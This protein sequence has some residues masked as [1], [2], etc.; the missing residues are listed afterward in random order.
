MKSHKSEITLKLSHAIK[1]LEGLR[2]YPEFKQ[3]DKLA[4]L[5]AI[6]GEV[7]NLIDKIQTNMNANV[8]TTG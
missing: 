1:V 4:A 7:K 6:T 5:E 2:P 3:P 8:Q